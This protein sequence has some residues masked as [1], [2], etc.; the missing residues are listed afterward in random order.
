MAGSLIEPYKST[1]LAK[2]L[3]MSLNIYVVKNGSTHSVCLTDQESLNAVRREFADDHLPDD[4][5]MA[6]MPC[7][8][9]NGEA[10]E[11]LQ[12]LLRLNT[13]DDDSIARAFEEI[14]TQ[15]FRA[16]MEIANKRMIQR[17][18]G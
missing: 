8:G 2:E 18:T 13:S 6:F 3:A 1:P 9:E 7:D 16:G 17:L 4:A 10:S 14:M 11:A 12:A 15:V 5:Y